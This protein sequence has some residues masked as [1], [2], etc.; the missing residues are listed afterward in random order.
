MSKPATDHRSPSRR[1]RDERTAAEP[2][3]PIPELP[4]DAEPA[5]LASH[6]ARLHPR[7]IAIAGVVE[8]GLVRPLD[9]AVKLREH[10]RVISW[11]PRRPDT[12][13]DALQ[14]SDRLRSRSVS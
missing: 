10:A 1:A 4:P 6:L 8:N 9:P 3:L 13:C 2:P 14:R 7:P 12:L 5:P 11:H